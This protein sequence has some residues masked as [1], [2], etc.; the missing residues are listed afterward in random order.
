MEQ[1]AFEDV[2]SSG[3]VLVAAVLA[4]QLADVQVV[5]VAAEQA[6]L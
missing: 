5:A 6:D 3:L 2:N 4:V 1:H